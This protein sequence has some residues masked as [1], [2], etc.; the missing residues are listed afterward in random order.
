[1]KSLSKAI[2][3]NKPSLFYLQQIIDD[4]YVFFE[5]SKLK[6]IALEERT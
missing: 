3:L 6:I 5:N 2:K 1:M 4:Q